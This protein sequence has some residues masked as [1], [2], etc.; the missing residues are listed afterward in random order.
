MQALSVL[1]AYRREEVKE[2]VEL[3]Q[4][5]DGNR[6]RQLSSLTRYMRNWPALC[7]A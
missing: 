4:E 1:E 7:L 3:E 5:M 6:R 2:T